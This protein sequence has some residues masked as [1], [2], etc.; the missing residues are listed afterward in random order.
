MMGSPVFLCG[1]M[2]CGKS[3]IGPLLANTLQIEFVDLDQCVVQDTGM[4][5]PQLFAAYGEPGFRQREHESLLKLLDSLTQPVVVATGGGIC[6]YPPN[7]APMGQR[8]IVVFLNPG[9]DQCYRRIRHTDRPL[10]TQNTPQALEQLYQKRLPG[11][12][13]AAHL[14]LAALGTPETCVKEI[15]EALQRLE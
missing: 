2:G 5:I 4:E 7:L 9:F 8:G 12:R 15:V 13:Q 1:F 6:T 3:T 14:E 11:Y 10:V